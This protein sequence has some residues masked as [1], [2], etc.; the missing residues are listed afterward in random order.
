MGSLIGVVE[1]DES[2]RVAIDALLRSCGYRTSSH[3][4]AES[5]IA[6]AVMHDVG[7]VIT[8]I[9]MGGLDG[10]D[11]K[12][13]IDEHA[14]GTPVIM[15]TAR[16]EEH[17]LSRARA[18]KPYCLLRKPFEPEDLVDCVARALEAGSALEADY[19]LRKM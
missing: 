16:A 3:S 19:Q 17:V 14:P 13:R 9:Q 4:S 11:L 1:D 18:S 6:S 5:F 8:D 2:L 10:I 12:R 7:C 15:V